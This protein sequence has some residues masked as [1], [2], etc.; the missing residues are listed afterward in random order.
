MLENTKLL[1]RGV[2]VAWCIVGLA[3]VLTGRLVGLLLVIVGI[4]YIARTTQKVE[5]WVRENP[6]TARWLTTGLTVLS[7]VIVVIFIVLDELRMGAQ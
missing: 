6:K 1:Q 4:V 5:V 3:I 7:A 2:G